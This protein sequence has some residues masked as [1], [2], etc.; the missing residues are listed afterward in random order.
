M[1][2]V[3]TT[4]SGFSDLL[5]LWLAQLRRRGTASA[6]VA[7]YRR[8]LLGIGGRIAG[9]SDANELDLRHL[10]KGSLRDAFASWATDHSPS[11]VRRAHS[12]WSRF[13]DFL[14]SEDRCDG[15]PMAAVA[16]PRG[17]EHAPRPIRAPD[18]AARML[19]AA[20]L[21]DPRSR[22]PWPERDVAL[23]ATFCVT[24]IR[25]AEAVALDVASLGGP[26]GNRRLVVIGRTGTPRS[27]PVEAALEEALGVY[28]TTRAT[29]FPVQDLHDPETPLFVDVR[30]DR[31]SAHQM[32][33]LIERLYV[34]ADLR[35]V[36]PRGALVHALRHTFAVS[37]ARAGADL[38]GLQAVL[39]HASPQTTRRYLDHAVVDLRHVVGSH[40]GQAALE[41]HLRNRDAS[42]RS[43]IVTGVDGKQV[44][45]E[46]R[47]SKD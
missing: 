34:R 37:A 20:A 6:T 12:A 18:A 33:Y 44:G 43:D 39:G 32:R 5:E 30:G 15:N 11:S 3:S 35:D 17:P 4:T 29:R 21:S 38:V 2:H 8:D 1:T 31:L 27:V 28:L 40:P 10:T 13:F 24:G 7:A 47:L 9:G 23:V 45:P 25:A 22:D 26:P 19:A 41:E 14:V 46:A 36:V 42:Y 16:K